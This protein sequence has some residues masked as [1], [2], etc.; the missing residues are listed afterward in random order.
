VTARPVSGGYFE[1]LGRVSWARW[2]LLSNS[3]SITM[4]VDEALAE[5]RMV[6]QLTVGPGFFEALGVPLLAGRVSSTATATRASHGIWVNAS[7]AEEFLGGVEGSVG[8]HLRVLGR[9]ESEVV[10]VV[11]NLLYSSVRDRVAPT[12]YVPRASE[13]RSYLLR[14]ERSVAELRPLV[15]SAVREASGGLIAHD[16]ESAH[17]RLR[18]QTRLERLLSHTAVALG[19][20]ALAMSAI[21]LY[22]VLSWSVERRR[23]EIGVRVSLGARPGDVLALVLC[24]GLAP[25]VAGL[26]IGAAGAYWGTRVTTGFLFGVEPLD[27]LAWLLAASVLALVATAAASVPAA[28]ASRLDPLVVLRSE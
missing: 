5:P 2:P 28:R 11:A 19:L 8:E 16:L 22:G 17:E 7:L 4:V 27:P 23:G 10:G 9:E 18:R 25:L 21:G 12:V 24:E 14:S 20:L 15:E 26:T 13:A 1:V 3:R 6:R